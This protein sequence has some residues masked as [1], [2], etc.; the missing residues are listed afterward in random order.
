MFYPASQGEAQPT[1]GHDMSNF[2]MLNCSGAHVNGEQVSV[3]LHDSVAES[4]YNFVNI[5]A[6]CESILGNQARPQ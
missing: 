6:G 2:R 1:Q 3:S 5:I 4:Y